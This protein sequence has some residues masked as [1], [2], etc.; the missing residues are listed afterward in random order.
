VTIYYADQTNTASVQHEGPDYETVWHAAAGTELW[1]YRP[2]NNY[3]LVGQDQ[4]G[5]TQGGDYIVQRLCVRFDTTALTP[6]DHAKIATAQLK[7]YVA[8][9]VIYDPPDD[10]TA[11]IL[12]DPGESY[13]VELSDYL[14]MQG[15]TVPATTAPLVK[16]SGWQT[17]NLTPTAIA[18][19][20]KPAALSTWVIRSNFE[21]IG[22]APVYIQGSQQ[23]L[24]VHTG[25]Y[26]SSDH[27]AQLI[28]TFKQ[29]TG[30]V[31]I[32]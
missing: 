27:T 14:L 15:A 19:G 6:A 13:P 11:S 2:S 3:H 21:I 9:N 17:V 20:I 10:I 18:V 31:Q 7:F 32:I 28:L 1:D 5:L 22:E 16:H 12:Q 24:H 26:G 29:R 8:W 23:F 30:W 25:W 4:L